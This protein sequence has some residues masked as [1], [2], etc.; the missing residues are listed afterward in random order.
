VVIQIHVGR[1]L[2]DD[3]KLNG[4]FGAKIIRGYEETVGFTF[5]QMCSLYAPNGGSRFE[6]VDWDHL[7]LK[8]THP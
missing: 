8:N 3:V 5:P 1:N 6:K 7:Q 2:V 4:G